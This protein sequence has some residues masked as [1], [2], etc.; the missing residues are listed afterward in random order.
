MVSALRAIVPMPFF[1]SGTLSI[2]PLFGQYH[3]GSYSYSSVHFQY[4]LGYHR[5]GILQIISHGRV[6]LSGEYELVIPGSAHLL[7]ATIVSPRISSQGTTTER[8]RW[9]EVHLP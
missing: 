6:F 2:I 5:G 4:Y 3:P 9:V 8:P 7:I 1:G